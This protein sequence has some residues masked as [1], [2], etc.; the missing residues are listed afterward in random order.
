[1]V[2]TEEK[3]F[4]AHKDNIC[5][6]SRFFASA[7]S[8]AWK[9]GAEKRV[10]LHDTEP[11]VFAVYLHW[12]YT[13]ELDTSFMPEPS[14]AALT[15]SYLNLAKAWV[16][17]DLVGDDEL[18]NAV[19]DTTIHRSTERLNRVAVDSLRFIC[20]NASAESALRRFH[21]D[22]AMARSTG[23]YMQ[24]LGPDVLPEFVLDCAKK[25]I[26]GETV[27]REDPK[28]EDRCKYHVHAGRG[29]CT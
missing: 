20:A 12:V 5:A 10:P 19:M 15:P 2:G 4:I 27:K 26:E 28:L 16:F 9:E 13:G 17:A 1:M 18:C 23:E 21:C 7:C 25:F 14:D 11:D 6:K 24:S 29:N 22:I 8:K 3:E